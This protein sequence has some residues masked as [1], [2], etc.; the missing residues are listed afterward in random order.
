[1]KKI[2]AI[3]ISDE[4]II[5]QCFTPPPV[6][7]SIDRFVAEFNDRNPKAVVLA[8]V[9]RPRLKSPPVDLRHLQIKSLDELG[10]EKIEQLAS[11]IENMRV[12]RGRICEPLFSSVSRE[13]KR[14]SVELAEAL[15]SGGEKQ[16]SAWSRFA[17]VVSLSKAALSQLSLTNEHQLALTTFL[18][19][20]AKLASADSM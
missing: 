8:V 4:E 2:M 13:L 19:E 17:G 5:A 18:N 9:G 20:I 12:A 15:G 7:T 14:V 1:M 16:V 6:D 3:D 11:K 10:Y